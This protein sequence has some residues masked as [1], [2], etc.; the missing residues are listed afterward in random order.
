[1]LLS[2]CGG[3]KYEYKDG[4]MYENKKP[5]T[6][7]LNFKSGDYKVKKSICRWC[8]WRST[9]KI[10]SR[11]KPYDKRCFGSEGIIQEEIYYKMVI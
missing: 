5:A 1:M 3:V 11:W 4:V 8:S 2:A 9:W 7:T 10:L 6:G